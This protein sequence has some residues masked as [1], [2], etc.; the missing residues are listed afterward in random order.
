MAGRLFGE[1][2]GEG[3]APQAPA[4]RAGEASAPRTLVIDMPGA[5]QAAVVAAVRGIDRADPDY[6]NLVVANAVL[7]SGSNGRLF[8][9]IRTKRALSYGAYSGM[10]A[11][12]DDAILTASAQTK[13]E[14]AAEVARIFLAELD[15]LGSEP[16]AA[17]AIEKRK[18]FV[19]G[20]YHRQA[21]SSAGFGSILAG[22][23]Q[24]GVPP[25][26]ASLYAGRIEDVTAQE[27]SSV[28]SR[29]TASDRATILIVGDASKFI[30]KLRALRPDAE[31]IPIDQLDLDSRTLRKA[32]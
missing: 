25:E 22:L 21:E 31:V 23:I 20:G 14:S 10:P 32:I 16:L 17:D 27:A 29:L 28:A 15:R 18:A 5:G 24:Q 6:Y 2:Q 12:M 1:W 13:N 3:T 11:R 4:A 9:E 8:E 30:D 19:T 26:E 7:G